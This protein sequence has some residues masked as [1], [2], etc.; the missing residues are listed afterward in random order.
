MPLIP[1][2]FYPIPH[3]YWYRSSTQGYFHQFN[4]E[5]LHSSNKNSPLSTSSL[6]Q[7]GSSL[8]NL[9]TLWHNSLGHPASSV[10][11][12]VLAS[13]NIPNRN[14]KDFTFYSACC[15]GK[16]HKFHFPS[17]SNTFPTPLHLI[18]TDLWGPSLS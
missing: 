14:K 17:A 18:H 2:I 8:S 3:Q 13:C 1:L 12:S 5:D 4:K 11:R 7:C 9:F 6:K 10:L 16:I 15:L